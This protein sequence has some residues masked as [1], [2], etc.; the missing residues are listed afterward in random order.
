MMDLKRRTFQRISRMLQDVSILFSR[1]FIG[2]YWKDALF[3]M[4]DIH[5]NKKTDGNQAKVTM[6]SD[7]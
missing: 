1:T 3:L 4:E 6:K 2:N 7:H 5:R